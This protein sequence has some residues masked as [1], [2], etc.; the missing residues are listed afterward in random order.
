MVTVTLNSIDGVDMP[1]TTCFSMCQQCN[2]IWFWS[3]LNWFTSVFMTGFLAVWC[4]SYQDPAK[5]QLLF[6]GYMC[7]ATKQV[8]EWFYFQESIEFPSWSALILY[9][10]RPQRNWW[11]RTPSC[12]SWVTLNTSGRPSPR[13]YLAASLKNKPTRRYVGGNVLFAMSFTS[14]TGIIATHIW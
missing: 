1:A 6:V 4:S 9:H 11:G 3:V 8:T 2:L 14:D 12:E 5:T 10:S 13:F 7:L